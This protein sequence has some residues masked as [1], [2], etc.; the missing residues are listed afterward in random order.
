MQDYPEL[1]GKGMSQVFHGQKMT[2]DAPEDV[3]PPMVRN[4]GKNFYVD[5]VLQRK[6]GAFFVPKRF[7]YATRRDQRELYALGYDVFEHEV[8]LSIACRASY[9]LDH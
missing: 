4:G 2:K 1:A 3:L 9:L 6:S 8:S 7:L 5:E